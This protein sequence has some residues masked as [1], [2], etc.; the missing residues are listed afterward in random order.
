M[1]E[2][3]KTTKRPLGLLELLPQ[4]PPMVLLDDFVWPQE[5]EQSVTSSVTIT[6]RSP[7]YSSLLQGV[8]A[9]TVIEYMAQTMALATGID[10]YLHDMPSSI[11]FLLG[12]RRLTLNVPVLPLGERYLITAEPIFTD[13]S[14][15]SFA[16]E[17]KSAKTGDVIATAQL[18]AFQP[19]ANFSGEIPS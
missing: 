4:K 1:D 15:G 8:P 5:G 19:D 6:E 9:C 14:F 10:H 13:E 11:G 2:M 3:N 12:S 17:V 7:F 16:C 18:T